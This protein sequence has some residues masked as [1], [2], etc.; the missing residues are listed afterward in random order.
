MKSH[1]SIPPSD[2]VEMGDDIPRDEIP[3]S[4]SSSVSVTRNA[5]VA[6]IS[7]EVERQR[8]IAQYERQQQEIIYN[9][10]LELVRQHAESMLQEQTQPHREE[11]TIA[12]GY[13]NELTEAAL[14]TLNKQSQEQQQMAAQDERAKQRINAHKN[15]LRN[16]EQ[17]K[18]SPE[19]AKPKAESEPQPPFKSQTRDNV[20]SSI[21]DKPNQTT[22]VNVNGPET[23]HEPKGPRGRPPNTQSSTKPI[24][25]KIEK[26]KNANPLHDTKKDENRTRTHWRKAAK[27]HLIYQLAK[28]GWK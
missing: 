6:D 21:R 25:R 24:R 10:Q 11:A 16:Q 9:Q 7:G 28:H 18:D 5:A 27:G 13:I 12:I 14:K 4:S 23:T 20:E 17:E 2:E 1:Y 26:P 8:Q 19:R 15:K 3:R 22:A